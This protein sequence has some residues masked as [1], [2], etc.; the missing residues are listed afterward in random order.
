V[1]MGRSPLGFSVYCIPAL[2]EDHD[3]ALLGLSI[4]NAMLEDPQPAPL[5]F[6]YRGASASPR[7]RQVPVGQACVSQ[8][9]DGYGSHHKVCIREMGASQRVQGESYVCQLECAGG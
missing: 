2:L 5:A 3:T 9:H 8:A 6:S 1:I 4:D 7:Q